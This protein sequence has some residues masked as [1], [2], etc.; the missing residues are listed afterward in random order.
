MRDGLVEGLSVKP[1]SAR[2]H[3]TR[4]SFHLGCLVAL[5]QLLV[6]IIELRLRTADWEFLTSPDEVAWIQAIEINPRR[7]EGPHGLQM[8][9]NFWDHH[10]TACPFWWDLIARSRRMHRAP[11]V[12]K[13]VI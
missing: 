12:Q 3:G 1:I 9:G 2:R 10:A 4:R 13:I 11:R 6:I 5:S 8:K 7:S